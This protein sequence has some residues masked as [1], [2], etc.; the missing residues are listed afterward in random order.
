MTL[1]EGVLAGK[2]AGDSYYS[3]NL[4]LDDVADFALAFPPRLEK[5]AAKT[6]GKP[7]WGYLPEAAPFGCAGASQ[8]YRPGLAGRFARIRPLICTTLTFV[9]LLRK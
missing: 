8:G 2:P 7:I 6:I 1:H 5:A 4:T 3:P 9:T